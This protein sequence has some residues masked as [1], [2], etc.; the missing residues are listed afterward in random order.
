MTAPALSVRGLT[1]AY[2]SHVV[3]R[4]L[5]LDVDP[6]DIYGFLGP[7]G[8]GKTTTMRMVLGLIHSDAGSVSIFGEADPVAARR[9]LGGIVEGPRFYPYLTGVANLRV[10]AAY[11]GG[12]T[13]ERIQSLL[14]MVRLGERQTDPVKTYSLGMR[15]R[16]GVAQALLG[17]PKLLLLDEPMNGLDPAGVRELRD[18]I[19]RLKEEEQLTV[20][21]SSHILKE[22]EG[23]CTRVGIIQDGRKVAEGSADELLEDGE[24]LEDCFLRLTGG[25]HGGQ[26]R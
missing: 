5:E 3:V 26:I 14:E 6:G 7:N 4:D 15:Q 24:S 1:R 13:E 20:F 8:A 16:L 21:I 23:L 2:G 19:L 10:F 11:S 9:H 17:A 25:V 18:L 12:V 22:I